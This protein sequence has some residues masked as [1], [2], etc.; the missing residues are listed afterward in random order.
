[1]FYFWLHEYKNVIMP[2]LSSQVTKHKSYFTSTLPG[3]L[4]S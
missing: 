3:L 4:L 1:M 2:I